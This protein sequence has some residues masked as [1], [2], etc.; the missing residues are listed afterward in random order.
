MNV[1]ADI[2]APVREQP[3]QHVGVPRDVQ[4]GLRS[5]LG[6]ERDVA[7]AD[8]AGI[9]E[10]Q[11]VDEDVEVPFRYDRGQF[12]HRRDHRRQNL[13]VSARRPTPLPCYPCEARR[14]TA[15]RP[16]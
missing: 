14:R 3:A 13:C 4:T 6:R 7:P 5:L 11:R 2:A 8:I 9:S 16:A 1:F 15:G 12:V 10:E